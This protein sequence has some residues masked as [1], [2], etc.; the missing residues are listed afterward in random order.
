MELQKEHRYL[1]RHLYA[2]VV[3]EVLVLDISN[4]CF[5]TKINKSSSTTWK[6]KDLFLKDHIILED[7]GIAEEF[8][9][10]DTKDDQL[11]Q[12]KMTIEDIVKKI[13]DEHG[14]KTNIED[15][16][17]YYYQKKSYRL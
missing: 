6:I 17:C 12:N 1:V 5:L 10:K 16:Y 2:N 7:L 3:D 4:T 9:K 11:Q 15:A 13:K 8:V 14:R